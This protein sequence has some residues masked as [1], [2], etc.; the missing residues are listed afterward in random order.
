VGNYNER[1]LGVAT[2]ERA[3]GV[4]AK[5]LHIHYFGPIPVSHGNY[6]YMVTFLVCLMVINLF[7]CDI[8]VYVQS[9]GQQSKWDRTKYALVMAEA[10]IG[11]V[12]EVFELRDATQFNRRWVESIPPL[13]PSADSR[14]LWRHCCL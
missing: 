8:A 3:L 13:S 10:P 6:T 12:G 7:K 4:A 11:M 1:A 5:A 2:Y 9:L 14:S